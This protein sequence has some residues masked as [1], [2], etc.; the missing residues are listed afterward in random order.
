MMLLSALPTELL[1]FGCLDPKACIMFKYF[2]SKQ[3]KANIQYYLFESMSQIPN[4]IISLNVCKSKLDAKFEGLRGR[5]CFYI[6][7]S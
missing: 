4:F 1:S 2:K 5:V 6:L 7:T 3:K